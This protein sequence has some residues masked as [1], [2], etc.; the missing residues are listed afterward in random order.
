MTAQPNGN[1]EANLDV[2]VI[3][4]DSCRYLRTIFLTLLEDLVTDSMCETCAQ[5]VA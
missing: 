2:E 3:Y 5:A 1:A 4:A